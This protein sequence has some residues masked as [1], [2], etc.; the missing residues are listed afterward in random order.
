MS[1]F[2]CSTGSCP[3]H[4]ISFCIQLPMFVPMA[5]GLQSGILR[6]DYSVETIVVSRSMILGGML[7]CVRDPGV[8]YKIVVINTPFQGCC[9][10]ELYGS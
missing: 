8:T 7:V 1:N 6:N 9:C 5:K 10:P 2:H 3:F 4:M